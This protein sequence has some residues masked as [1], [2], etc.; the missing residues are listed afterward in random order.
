MMLSVKQRGIKYHFFVFGMT[1]PGT[2]PRSLGLMV[3][4]VATEKMCS[5]IDPTISAVLDQPYLV[6]NYSDVYKLY[7]GDFLN[8]YFA[9]QRKLHGVEI[10]SSWPYA[11]GYS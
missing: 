5:F 4:S 7:V 11:S 6:S 2:E 1:R 9:K 10:H 3:N 8:I